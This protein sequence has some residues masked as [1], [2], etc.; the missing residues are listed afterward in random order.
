MYE[1]LPTY[2][3]TVGPCFT[4]ESLKTVTENLLH[5]VVKL[6]FPDYIVVLKGIEESSIS[7][8]LGEDS[9]DEEANF[10]NKIN[11]YSEKYGQASFKTLNAVRR[12]IELHEDKLRV[13]NSSQF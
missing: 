10:I 9:R 1:V 3:K 13:I 7:K 4:K 6:V 12:S 2:A 8:Q 11:F 5:E